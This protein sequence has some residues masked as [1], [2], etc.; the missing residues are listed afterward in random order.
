M[1][2]FLLPPATLIDVE[3]GFIP[4]TCS[5]GPTIPNPQ[6]RLLQTLEQYDSITWL[7]D[8]SLLHSRVNESSV[9]TCYPDSKVIENDVFVPAGS[10]NVSLTRL[11]KKA[12]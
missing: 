10:L 5:V 3:R 7:S 11:L 12:S 1:Q 4:I 6:D 8:D 2:S 9:F